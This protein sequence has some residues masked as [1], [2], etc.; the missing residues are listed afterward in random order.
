MQVRPVGRGPGPAARMTGDRA[1]RLAQAREGSGRPGRGP[2]G[3]SAG[4]PAE[5]TIVA[6]RVTV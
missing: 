3:P 2:I 5:C 1:G 6:V 4:A